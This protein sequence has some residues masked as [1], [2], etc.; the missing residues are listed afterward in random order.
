MQCGVI[1]CQESDTDDTTK[2]CTSLEVAA[3]KGSRGTQGDAHDETHYE[4]VS[5]AGAD[6][7]PDQKPVD[8]KKKG[9]LCACFGKKE[10]EAEEAKAEE[11]DHAETGLGNHIINA[12]DAH[13]EKKEAAADAAEQAADAAPAEA[14]A[15]AEGVAADA[16]DV[17]VDVV[18]DAA[19]PAN[20][21]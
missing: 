9:G 16:K 7:L 3:I 4:E 6:K 17:T 11:V 8:K 10:E 5:K 12:A 21:A 14:A 19:A 1:M 15:A 18:E 2:R 20:G 13:A